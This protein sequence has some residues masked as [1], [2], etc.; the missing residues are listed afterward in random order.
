MQ[1]KR[2][3]LFTDK[4]YTPDKTECTIIADGFHTGFSQQCTGSLETILMLM[5][6]GF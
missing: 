3:L 5:L 6:A 1:I 2:R 4:M